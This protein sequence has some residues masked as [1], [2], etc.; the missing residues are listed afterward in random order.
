MIPILSIIQAGP[1]LLRMAGKMLGGKAGTVAEQ[2]ANVVE[3]VGHLPPQEAETQV[4]KA[5]SRIPEENLLELMKVVAEMDR[6]K[7]EQALAK[8]NADA[9]KHAETQETARVEAVSEDAEVRRTR[10]KIAQQSATVTFWYVM[11]TGVGFPLIAIALEAYIKLKAVTGAPT[12]LEVL[13]LPGPDWMI[14][15]TLF[16]PCLAYMGARTAEVFSKHGD[17][18]GGNGAMANLLKKITG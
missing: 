2:A 7:G 4:S 3:S 15:G 9:D 6:V 16:A 11:L 18:T 10:P 8:I 5:L 12:D 17:K 1:T 13:A 14:A